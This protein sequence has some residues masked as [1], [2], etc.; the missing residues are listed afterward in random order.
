MSRALGN[1]DGQ[2]IF[3]RNGMGELM[4]I[5]ALSLVA[6]HDRSPPFAGEDVERMVRRHHSIKLEARP[7][8]EGMDSGQRRSEPSARRRDPA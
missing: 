7:H 4:L 5:S 1:P 3:V 2:P 8:I 6:G